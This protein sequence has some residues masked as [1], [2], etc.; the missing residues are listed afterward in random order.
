MLDTFR[1]GIIR[2]LSATAVLAMMMAPAFAHAVLVSAEP[3]PD[4]EVTAPQVITLHFSEAFEPK[5]SGFTLTDTDGA[6]VAVNPVDSKDPKTM[7]ASPAAPLAPGL[8]T[9]S[10]KTLGDDTHTRNGT[11]SFTVK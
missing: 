3:A 2:G 10:W 1:T 8:Y 4:S 5:F 6:K 9:I 11:F 7:A